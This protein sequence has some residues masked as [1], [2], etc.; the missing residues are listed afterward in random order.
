MEKLSG[1]YEIICNATDAHYVGRSID[2]Y[3]R[4]K[5]HLEDLRAK[6]HH[7]DYLQR[8][9]NKYGEKKFKFKIIELVIPSKLKQR[10]NFYLKNNVGKFNMMLS[11]GGVLYHN[12]DTRKKMTK[13]QMRYWKRRRREGRI[14][15][16]EET[17]EAISKSHIGIRPNEKSREKMSLSAKKRGMAHLNNKKRCKKGHLFSKHKN[18]Y[19][20]CSICSKERK[21]KWYL[22]NK[23]K[24]KN[25]KME[26]IYNDGGR[27]SAGYKG[28]TRDCVCRSICIITG[29]PYSEVYELLANNNSTQRKS[30]KEPKSKQGVKTAS[31]GINIKRKWFKDYMK[32]LG[33][34]WIPTMK[35][36]SG[37]KVHLREGELPKGKLIVS[38][39]KHLT[40][41]IDGVIN[42]TH[43]CSRGGTRAVYG[44]YRLIKNK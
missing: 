25:K 29:K 41:V 27:K 38:V 5:R 35:I 18:K 6:K 22:K 19:H 33:F 12:D 34:E 26:F 23:L 32:S 43:D 31:K 39:S 11:S 10:E 28:K 40:A 42:D 24:N 1:I 8:A 44:Y 36:G 7:S 3:S 20:E 13:G 15:Q 14:Y 30:K 37:C 4:W 9:W 21:R 2:I 16:T 17:K